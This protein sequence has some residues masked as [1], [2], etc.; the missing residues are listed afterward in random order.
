[1]RALVLKYRGHFFAAAPW[2]APFFIFARRGARVTLSISHRSDLHLV[3][4][5]VDVYNDRY[6]KNL[7]DLWRRVYLELKG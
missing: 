3:L 6:K 5:S 1:M 2:A 7:R 4:S